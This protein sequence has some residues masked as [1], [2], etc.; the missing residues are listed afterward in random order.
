MGVCDANAKAIELTLREVGLADQALERVHDALARVL[1][2]SDFAATDRIRSFLSYVV[3]EA[4]A[5]RSDRIKAYS[6]ATSVFGRAADFDPQVDSIVRIEAGRLRRTLEHYYLTGGRNDPVQLRIPKGSYVPVFVDMPTD[7]VT[8]KAPSGEPA[9]AA[10]RG[11]SIL[12]EP[13]E[14]EGDCAV[15]PHF[16]SGFT[17]SLVI[18][19]ARFPGLRILK[20]DASPSAA[21]RAEAD[22]IVSGAIVVAA[23][24]LRV[25][26]ILVEARTGVTLWADTFERNLVPAEIFALRAELADRVAQIIAQPYGVI[27]ATSIRGEADARPQQNLSGVDC[28]MF[29]YAYWRKF[30][31]SL[32]EQTRLCLER[33]IQQ[34]PGD[35]EAHACLSLL[36]ANAF[37]FSH[38]LDVLADPRQRAMA[39]AERAVELAPNSSWSH[40]A[41]A[42]AYW[43]DGDV[44]ASLDAFAI[45]RSL[46]PNDTTINA[47]LGQRYAMLGAWDRAVQ[48]LEESY[49][50]NPALPGSYRIGLFLFHYAH[51]RYEDAL[52]E[53]SKTGTPDVV[54]GHV[55][56]AVSAAHLGRDDLVADAIAQIL[57]IDPT[58]GDH[59]AA[60]LKGRNLH[61]D[62]AA[63]IVAGLRKAGL[64]G[65]EIAAEE[66]HASAPWP[67]YARR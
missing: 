56:I 9:T 44:K 14:Q 18:D 54:Y 28:I 15:Y 53:A 39:L 23:E 42:T 33:T 67:T 6:I 40:Y 36:Y 29:F 52:R 5:G 16:A 3:G 13:F 38:K 17:R 58:Y 55:A 50:R 61:P 59:V 64:R 66:E 43:F 65:A 11:K 37:R 32:I 30:D 34:E 20:F 48:L 45:A 62:L 10:R 27:H 4:L 46:N 41:R 63:M 60:D 8:S 26:A 51:G 2:S 12:V 7:A 25:E 21:S 57:A 31:R 19:L 47:D 24:H 49:A 1:A 35:A 22:Y